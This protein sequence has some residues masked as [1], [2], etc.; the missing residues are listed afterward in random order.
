[1]GK[2]VVDRGLEEFEI[3]DKNG[4]FLG[5]FSMNPADLQMIKRYEEVVGDFENLGEGIDPEL[6]A[7]E[8]IVKAEEKICDLFDYLFNAKVSQ[9]I[10]SITSPYTPLAN[11]EVFFINVLNAI[12]GLIEKETG[13]RYKKVR[14]KMNKY[15]EKYRRG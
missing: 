12:S 11:G 9:D 1:M 2:I 14:D 7:D 13:K 15:T 10:F 3:V 8:I 5:K 6:P 4:E